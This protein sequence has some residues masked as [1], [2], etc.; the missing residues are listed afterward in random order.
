VAMIPHSV[1]ST[2]ASILSQYYVSHTKI[3]LLFMVAGAPGDPPVGNMAT[4]CIQWFKRCNEDETVN[5]LRVLGLCIQALMDADPSI[6][7][8]IS[9]AQH[10]IGDSLA[11]N[12]LGYQLNGVVTVA[13]A[14]LTT[15]TLA[16][17]FISGDFVS[18]EA[19]FTRAI[20]H[21]HADPHAAITAASSIIEALCK[22]YIETFGLEMPSKQSIVPLWRVVQEHFGLNIDSLLADD[23]RKILQGLSA[24]VDGVGAYRT[25]IG[26][27]HGRG[28][29]PPPIT[30]AEARLAVNASHTVV[31]FLM[32]RWHSRD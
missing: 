2:V 9:K 10:A 4:K 29:Q 16:D 22:T 6:D 17:F 28:L 21:L 7:E 8:R 32:E 20:T 31:T 26:S 1:M 14:G 30:V 11:K 19:E 25:H 3:N 18:I 5:P 15:K 27:A 23:Q 24:I 12:Q 13:G